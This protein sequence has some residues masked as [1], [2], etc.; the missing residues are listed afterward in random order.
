MG[1]CGLSSFVVLVLVDEIFHDVLLKFAKFLL[2]GLLRR[3]SYAFLNFILFL[4]LLLFRSFVLMF[5]RLI[6]L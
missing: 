5:A 6:L 3:S 4:L 1:G 2:D